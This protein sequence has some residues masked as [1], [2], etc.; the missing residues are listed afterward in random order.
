[1]TGDATTDLATDP[2]TDPAA[3]YARLAPGRYRSTVHAQGAWSAGEQHMGPVSGLLVHEIEQLEPRDDL[4][5]SRISFDILGVIPMGIVQVRSRVR[6]P[7]RTI[8]L[9]EAELY[10]ERRT[11]VRAHAWR[12]H[13]SDTATLAAVEETRMAG[14]DSG[15]TWKGSDTWPGGYIDS[16]EF[17]VLPGWRPGRGQVWLRSK[18]D[19]V[20]P[21]DSTEMARYVA[22]VDTANGIAVRVEPGSLL[23]PN[24]DLTVHLFRQPR[25]PWVGLDTAV[26]FGATGIGVTS[27]TLHDLDGPVGRAEQIL[28]IRPVSGHV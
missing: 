26:T 13:T 18:V 19:L 14:P 10:D 8:E 9:V 21:E 11:L 24:T 2:A 16:L 27:A 20:D 28:T 4:M 1:M 12:L 6:R 15:D 23:F 5:L 7:G 22:L 25:G 17:R 3:Y